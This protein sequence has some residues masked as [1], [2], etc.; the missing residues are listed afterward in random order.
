MS[1]NKTR[2]YAA[3]YLAALAGGLGFLGVWYFWAWP[4]T[5]WVLNPLGAAASS[6]G[7][8]RMLANWASLGAGAMLLALAVW[9][10]RRFLAT[11]G[12]GR[13]LLFYHLLPLLALS[14]ALALGELVSSFFV[15]DW[16]A[17]ELRPVV[18]KSP[19]FNSWGLRDK[20]R[21]LTKKPGVR[22]VLF[23]GD[24][25]L[26]GGFVKHTLPEMVGRLLADRG[27]ERVECV[28]LG[29]SGTGPRQ[30]YYRLKNIGLKLGPNVVLLFLF[31]GNDFLP[32][33]KSR[34]SVALLPD[35]LVAE[36]PEPSWL[37]ML[38]PRL[39]WLVVNR[40]RMSEMVNNSTADQVNENQI[41]K[42]AAQ[43]PWRQGVELLAQY[44]H[45]YYYPQLGV[46]KIKGI[47][48]KGAPR[49]WAVLQ[50]RGPDPEHLQGWILY[51]LIDWDILVRTNDRAG[52][53]PPRQR[54]AWAESTFGWVRGMAELCR[55]A[56]VPMITFV[57]PSAEQVDP[58]YR[59]LWSPWPG[60]MAMGGLR[61]QL[62]D[63]LLGDMRRAGLPVHDLRGLLTGRE[64]TYRITDAHWNTKGHR[65]VAA[66]VAGVVQ[67]ALAGKAGG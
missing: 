59:R 11:G 36:R 24:S 8:L 54:R 44:M 57:I 6:V 42:K 50:K 34:E 25:F 31:A 49:L 47:L 14:A 39:T 45:R 29:I 30:Y 37:G 2:A 28:N 22:R 48:S 61:G 64:G 51:N 65:L 46:E 23:L 40:L 9:S 67:R 56:G 26:E 66:E 53:M 63:L 18:W 43:M 38:A 12:S 1:L 19:Q 3:L 41:M 35:K 21:S 17:R 58:A 4:H 32:P 16:P 52:T 27:V 7:G 20:E 13:H 5:G 60:Q 55:R 10:A 15:P 33:S 62:S